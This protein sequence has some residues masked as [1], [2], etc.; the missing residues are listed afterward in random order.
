[1][2][3]TE[4]YK[5]KSLCTE[6]TKVIERISHSFLILLEYLLLNLL[7]SELYK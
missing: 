7:I 4:H 1:M 6:F 5:D 2:I 3:S